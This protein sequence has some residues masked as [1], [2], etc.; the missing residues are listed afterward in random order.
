MVLI[1]GGTFLMGSDAAWWQ[2][3]QKEHQ[4]TV[5]SFCMSKYETTY[6][7]WYEVRGWAKRCSLA[8]C[9]RSD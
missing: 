7:L 2:K 6:E 4:V 5:S 1:P 8:P 9:H 3:E